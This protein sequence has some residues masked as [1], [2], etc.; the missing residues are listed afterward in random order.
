MERLLQQQQQQQ[1]QQA[2]SGAVAG[3]SA[4]TPSK[5][6]QKVPLTDKA[7]VPFADKENVVQQQGL[8]NR[9]LNANQMW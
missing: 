9:Q 6:T 5:G 7:A 3:G 8:V 2:C 1:Q 4:G